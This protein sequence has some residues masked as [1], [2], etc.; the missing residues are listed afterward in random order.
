MIGS[1]VNLAFVAALSALEL[2]DWGEG[3][4]EAADAPTST[5]APESLHQGIPKHNKFSVAMLYAVFFPIFI[6]LRTTFAIAQN[7]PQPLPGWGSY[8]W[9]YAPICLISMLS[10]TLVV[11]GLAYALPISLGVQ[12]EF[13]FGE[14]VSFILEFTVCVLFTAEV[15]KFFY[16]RDQERGAPE[17][18][19][20][21][22]VIRNDG[23]DENGGVGGNC[24]AETV[25][26]LN[27]Y[28][29]CIV[30]LGCGFSCHA[31]SSFLMLPPHVR[32]VPLTFDSSLTHKRQDPLAVLPFY[33]ASSTTDMARLLVACG[34]HP[35]AQELAMSRTSYKADKYGIHAF[36]QNSHKNSPYLYT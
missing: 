7:D 34:L 36:A 19:E 23:G 27:F 21:E 11:G 3:E 15:M 20:P 2:T 16:K 1:A 26:L 12:L 8:S 14:T 17:Q 35:V 25:K 22:N 31:L 28:V 9:K 33:R 5:S 30:G 32:S 4:A 13:Y 24:F 29:I 18:E 10:S 6:S